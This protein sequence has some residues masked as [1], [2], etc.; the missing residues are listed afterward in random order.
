MKAL[1]EKSEN[2]AELDEW[3]CMRPNM[4]PLQVA[5][6]IFPG[7]YPRFCEII[8]L[9]GASGMVSIPTEKDFGSEIRTDLDQYLQAYGMNAEDRV[10]LFRLAWDLTM[11]P[12]G[13]RQTQYERYFFGDPIRLTSELYRNYLKDPHVEDIIKFL[14]LKN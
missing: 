12:F 13:T 2:D 1:L 11:S 3:G 5:S 6:N 14:N 4:I 8:Q 7:I 9:I 10:K